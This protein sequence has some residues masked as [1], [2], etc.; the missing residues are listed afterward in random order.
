[1]SGNEE[2]TIEE[3][4]T[5]PLPIRHVGLDDRLWATLVLFFIT[6]IVWF[7]IV[8]V[9]ASIEKIMYNDI[10]FFCFNLV[11]DVTAIIVF[12]AVIYAIGITIANYGYGG[13]I[14][15]LK[16]PGRFIKKYY[17]VARGKEALENN[18]PDMY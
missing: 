9:G 11:S 17:R 3:E 15:N 4:L 14:H 8:F 18:F 13:I 1:M 16:M 2:R 6:F 5:Y 12:I 7:G 10:I